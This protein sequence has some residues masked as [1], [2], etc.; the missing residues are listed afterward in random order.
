MTT[1]NP[2]EHARSL[3]EELHMLANIATPPDLLPRTL[4]RAGLADIYW[5]V[6]TP[7]GPIFIAASDRGISAVA[8]GIDTAAFEAAHQQRTG[9]PAKR[10]GDPPADAMREVDALLRGDRRRTMPFDLRGL[11]EFEEAVLRK[12]LEIPRGQVRP[13]SWIAR[14]IGHPGAARAAGSALAHNP[15]PLLIPCHRVV[16][17]D[18][19]IG[20]YIFGS[21]AKRALLD[22]EDADPDGLTALARQ[23]IRY[24]GSDTTK[25]F[26]WPTCHHARRTSEAHLVSFHSEREAREAGY[27]PCKV[28]RPA[29]AS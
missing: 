12:A 4:Q 27:R 20:N 9:R 29:L 2:L 24:F 7:I 17:G 19:T 26:C 22:W 11:S 10:I 5:P 6:E 15:V 25:I 14:E 3:E 23:G 16:R 18:G 13:Y 28:C 21:E 1:G 8:R